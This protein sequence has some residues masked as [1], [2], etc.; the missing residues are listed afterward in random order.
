MYEPNRWNEDDWKA[1][2]IN[3]PTYELR[4]FVGSALDLPQTDV[5]VESDH[6]VWIPDDGPYSRAGMGPIRYAHRRDVVAWYRVHVGNPETI[7]R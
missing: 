3:H 6:S 7:H 4:Q 5:R 2:T 1:I